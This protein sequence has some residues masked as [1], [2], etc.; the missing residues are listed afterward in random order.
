MRAAHRLLSV[1]VALAAAS[2]AFAGVLAACATGASDPDPSPTAVEAGPVEAAAPVVDAA[3]DAMPDASPDAAFTV[4]DGAVECD[5]APCAVALSAWGGTACAALANGTVACWGGNDRGQ[6]G[7]DAGSDFPPASVVARPVEGL[8]GAT[9]VSV[10]DGNACARL[11]DAGVACWGATP[12]LAVGMSADAGAPSDAFVTTP[13]PMDAVPAAANVAVGGGFAC[14]TT[15]AGVLSCWGENGQGELGRGPTA[16]NPAGPGSVDLGGAIAAFARPG[17]TRAFVV[18]TGGT[19]ESWGTTTS[20]GS[21]GF[22][23]GRDSSEDP[24]RAPAPIGLS[25][26]RA[27]ATGTSH[28]CAVV[29]RSVDCWGSNESGQLGRGT[30]G[31]TWSLPDRSRLAFTVADEDSDAGIFAS[32]DVALDVAV[33]DAH[34]CAVMGSGR[35]YC[36]GASYGGQIGA[37]A[38]ADVSGVPV[39]VTGLSG[40]AVAVAAGASSTCALLRTGAVECWGTNY[41]GEL[42]SGTLDQVRH[43]KPARVALP[44]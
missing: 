17:P 30:F 36:W 1:G 23:L 20:M 13:L 2:A 43:P 41:R 6:L 8:S 37:G 9:Q 39:K 40:P 10:G 31:P 21:Y 27:V 18:T 34:T 12:L 26:V 14:V 15:P 4:P 44:Q 32:D 19:L 3:V 29:E 25:L 24:D 16:M 35:V 11:A 33:G 7:Y 28:A 22:L 5:A 38:T 42:G